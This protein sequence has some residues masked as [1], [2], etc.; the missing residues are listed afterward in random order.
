[1]ALARRNSPPSP[2]LRLRRTKARRSRRG[3]LSI[4]FPRTLQ[5]MS[6][7]PRRSGVASACTAIPTATSTGTSNPGWSSGE[8]IGRRRRSAP[9]VSPPNSLDAATSGVSFPRTFRIAWGT[10]CHFRSG[11]IPSVPTSTDSTSFPADSSL[12]LITPLLL[13][14]RPFSSDALSVLVTTHCVSY[15]FYYLKISSYAC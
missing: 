7:L 6:S 13:M 15:H 4:L 12:T 8:A 9:S 11:I 1:M 10:R 14:A 2:S 5:M 3:A